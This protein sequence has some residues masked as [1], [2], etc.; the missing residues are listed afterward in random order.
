MTVAGSRP[1]SLERMDEST[2]GVSPTPDAWR[3]IALGALVGGVAIGDLAAGRR[4]LGRLVTVAAA[5]AA[6]SAI[7]IALA[8]RRPPIEPGSPPLDPL[9]SPPTMS[10]IV[11]ARDEA[12]VLPRLVRDIAEQDY[13]TDAGLPMFE[14]IVVD[15]RSIDGTA[16]AALRAAAG[17][18]IG[19]VTRLVR[20]GEIEGATLPDGKGAALTAAQPEICRGDVVV[21]LDADARVGPSFL[22]TIAGYI[23]AGADALTC[24]RRI[25]GAREDDL[26]GAQADEQTIDGELQRGRW[27][28]GGCSELRGDGIVVRRDLLERVGGW[29]A[30]ALTEDLDLSS[31]LAAAEGVRV[32][33]AIDA[34]VWEEPVGDWPSLWR[35]RLRWAEGSIRRT[36]EHGAAVVRSPHLSPTARLDFAVYAGQLAMPPVIIGSILGGLRR[37]RIGLP[38]RLLAL[39]VAAAAGLAWD[40]LRWEHDEA[41]RPL[42]AAERARR[43]V[44]AVG[45]GAIW[46]AA[47]PMALW[48]LATH[49]GPLRYDKMDHGSA[50]LDGGEGFPGRSSS[51]SG[52]RRP[53]G[54]HDLAEVG[55]T[56]DER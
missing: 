2:D 15:D 45:F 39:Y 43:A 19:D 34:Q 25:A 22:R 31:R 12:A 10:V 9:A 41:G 40:A 16:Q 54:L 38:R 23:A 46:L 35:Q 37:G 32:A 3:A 1:S 47:V 51:T 49:D 27:A 50:A 29:R 30:E 42:P 5:G 7:P 8:S 14:V 28:L 24:R 6:L 55:P 11:A 52:W 36:L 21:V 13:R 20:R 44:R 56:V 17:A 18:G 26:A 48:R 53:S 33:W 4:L